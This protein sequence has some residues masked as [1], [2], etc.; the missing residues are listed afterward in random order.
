MRIVAIAVMLPCLAAPASADNVT[1]FG[2]R[3]EDGAS[4]VYGIPDSGYGQIV[5][6]CEAGDDDLTFVYEH[7]PNDPKDGVEVDVI[8]SAGDLEISVPT[9]GSRLEIDDT[10]IL[11]GQTKLDDKLRNILQA[12][13]TMIVT[14]EDGTAE[15]PLDGAA[16]AARDLIEVCSPQG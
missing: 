9:T 16:D 2:N 8:L 14:V 7:Q 3:H 13:G 15:Y 4:L 10:F 11:E 6:S 12:S 5:L 1:W